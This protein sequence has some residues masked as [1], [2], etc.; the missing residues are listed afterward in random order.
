MAVRANY[1]V[2]R[3]SDPLNEV[4]RHRAT[5]IIGA[6]DQMYLEDTRSQK[7]GSLSLAVSF[8]ATHSS[9]L[10]NRKGN[11]DFCLAS[12]SKEGGRAINRSLR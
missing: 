1:D 4:V 12:P 7:H 8:D 2:R 9:R 10:I 11:F 6:H 3:G 5:E